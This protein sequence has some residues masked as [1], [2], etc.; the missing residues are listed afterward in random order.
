[1]SEPN[2]NRGL[3]IHAGPIEIDVPRSLGYYGGIAAAVGIGMIEPPLG[4]FI[5][6]IPIV[7]M[8]TRGDAPQLVRL[9]GQLFDGAAKPVGG[10][11]EGTIR[12]ENDPG[13]SAASPE[14]VVSNSRRQEGSRFI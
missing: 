7:K 11:A 10:D 12:A 13:R 14:T 9:L 3:M 8:L 2:P 5:G 6:A 4:L 1:M